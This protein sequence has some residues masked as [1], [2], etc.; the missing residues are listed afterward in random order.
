MNETKA[1]LSE[2]TEEGEESDHHE[3]HFGQTN[4]V[5]LIT[6]ESQRPLLLETLDNT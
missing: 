6:N 1:P 4:F 5:E 2:A 3:K